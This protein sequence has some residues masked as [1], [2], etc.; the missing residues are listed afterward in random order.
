MSLPGQGAIG[1]LLKQQ[2]LLV[3]Q[4]MVGQLRETQARTDLT[5][6]RE[7]GPKCD[8]SFNDKAIFMTKR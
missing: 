8:I 1:E 6:A 7:L 2:I 5:L 4:K 3:R